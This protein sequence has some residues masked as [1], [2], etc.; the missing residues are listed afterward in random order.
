MKVSAAAV[1]LSCSTASAFNVGYLNQLGGSAAP[2]KA[3]PAFKEVVS[4]GPA[5][6]LDNLNTPELVQA[7]E[8]APAPAPVAPA[9][10]AAAP[11]AAAP[12]AGSY[13]DSMGSG[14]TA[15]T[16]GGLTGYLDA[17]G[18][19][20]SALSGGGITGYLDALPASNT[21]LSG[22]GAASYLDSVGG[23]APAAPAA[24]APAAAAPAPVAAAPAAPGP[25]P[26]ADAP[27]AG[28]YLSTLG[29][30]SSALVGGG[31]AGYLDALPATNTQ[32][33]GSGVVGYTDALAINASITGAGAT[34]YLDAIAS[35]TALS[36][37][38]TSSPSVTSFLEN[39]YSQIMS[40]P[41]D[42]R[43]VSGNTVTFA[44]TSGPYAMSFIKN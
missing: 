26:V 8:T 37:P 23:S 19:G 29:G 36:G 17:M 43:T 5:S 41:A 31:I 22:S 1:I 30:G 34:G 25:V 3:A 42:Q 13:L 12:S 20:S 4:G 16:G 44:S 27:S 18:A 40:L 15:I 28:D 2:A 10:V 39:V 35:N 6:Y 7:I 14:S 21:A 38:S 9:P 33:S 32:T 11:V 24:A